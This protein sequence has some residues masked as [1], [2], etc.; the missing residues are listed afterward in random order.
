MSDAAI[1]SVLVVDD[2]RVSHAMLAAL[3]QG[4]CRVVL[5]KH[6]GSALQRIRED[7]SICLVLL[8][9]SM[10]EMS[11]YDV[12]R[13]LRADPQ[14]ADVQVVF[15]SGATEEEDEEQGLRLG[16]IDYVLKPIRPAIVRVRIRNHLTLIAQR[17]ELERL[18]SRDGLTGIANRRYF[19]EA[20]ASACYLATRRSEALSSAMIDVDDFKAYN[21]NYG[22]PAGD[23]ALRKIAHVMAGFARRPYDVAARYGGEDFVLLLPDIV[24]TGPLLEK[25]RTDVLA[26]GLAHVASRVTDVVS[27]SVGA[28]T[29]ETVDTLSPEALVRRADQLLYIAKQQGRNRVILSNSLT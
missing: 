29:V 6:G 1:Q 4:E 12:L 27:I 16:A 23:D 2:D 24:D 18:A 22:H 9:V 11:G 21:D 25:L 19:S 5:A 17:K 26:L 14:T 3:L 10:P 8:D 7:T 15:I 28:V 13:K 20:L